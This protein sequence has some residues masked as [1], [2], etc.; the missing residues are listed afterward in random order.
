MNADHAENLLAYC[1]HYHQLNPQTIE[2]IG[3]DSLGFDV[4]L[5]TDATLR[6]NFEQAITNAQEARLALVAMAKACRA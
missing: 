6:F 3:I 4:R 5:D 2:M 1:Q